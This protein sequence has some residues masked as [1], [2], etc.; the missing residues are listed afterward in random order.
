VLAY[1]P[2]ERTRAYY[3]QYGFMPSPTDPQHLV[4]RIKDVR[5]SLAPP[6]D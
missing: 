2:D 4:V 1:A 5:K 3:A 6:Q